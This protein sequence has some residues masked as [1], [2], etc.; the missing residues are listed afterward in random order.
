MVPFC[1]F[2]LFQIEVVLPKLVI[3]MVPV[4]T[5]TGDW[6]LLSTIIWTLAS[7]YQ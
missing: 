6:K 1:F 5:V 2:V 3:H 4:G 7:Y